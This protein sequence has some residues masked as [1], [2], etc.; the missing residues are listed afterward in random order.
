MK[1]TNETLNVTYEKSVRQVRFD[2]TKNKA[3]CFYLKALYNTLVT[4]KPK[5]CI[6]IGTHYGDNSTPV[7]QQYFDEHM[8]DGLL[9][10]CDIK[11]YKDISHLKNVR[12]VIVAHHI[13]NIDKLHRVSTS[14]L[15]FDHESSV[16]IN[17]QLLREYQPEYDFAFID[18]DHTTESF[19]KDIQICENLLK[20]PKVML[21]DDTKT[22]AHDCM[23]YYNNV[24]K[25]L[26]E[27][28]CYDFNDWGQFV[29][30]SLVR[31]KIQI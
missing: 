17:T 24:I 18:G 12:Q 14:E 5:Y 22:P 29:G 3:N 30:C 8:P 28:E 15:K 31:K 11:K 23:H 20:N 19:R 2:L 16:E 21:I 9:V 1:I 13:N 6:E 25:K 7:F 4:F 26:N 27:Y 10:T